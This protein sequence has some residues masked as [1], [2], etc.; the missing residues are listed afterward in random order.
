MEAGPLGS[1]P[2]IYIYIYIYIYIW[3]QNRSPIPHKWILRGWLFVSRR[4]EA[5]CLGRRL[6]VSS[7][8]PKREGASASAPRDR[9][10]PNGGG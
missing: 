10:R 1:S 2:Q 9:S 6:R 8:G 3:I 7:L 4:G 5:R